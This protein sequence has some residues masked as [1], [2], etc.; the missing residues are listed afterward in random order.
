M[1]TEPTQ[2]ALRAFIS[3][4]IIYCVS[5]LVA[6]LAEGYG[7]PS[8]VEDLCEEAM[9]LC[10]PTEDWLSSAIEN[11]AKIACRDIDDRW[12]VL[13]QNDNGLWYE[14]FDTEEG[15][16]RAY[17]E[18]YGL[19]PY[20]NEIY[21]H[22]LIDPWLADRLEEQGERV[23]RLAGMKIWGRSTTGQAIYMDKVTSQIWR[24]TR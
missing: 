7:T 5:S 6:D 2:E 14:T 19:D 3:N 20:N 17:C 22:W 18:E 15:A 10:K 13:D 1:T 9:D 21:E 12:I 8:R 11:G 16:A 23:G 24:S 4:H